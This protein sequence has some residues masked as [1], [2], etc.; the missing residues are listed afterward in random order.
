M[1]LDALLS[2]DIE[3]EPEIAI[4]FIHIDGEQS[5]DERRD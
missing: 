1:H 3:D 4:E 2:Y 5:A